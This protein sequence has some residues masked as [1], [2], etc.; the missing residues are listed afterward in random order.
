MKLYLFTFLSLFLTVYLYSCKTD[1]TLT[2][3]PSVLHFQAE[4]GAQSFTLTTDADAWK[5]ANPAPGWITLSDS[6]GNTPEA[7]ITI[8]V[9]SKTL[10]ARTDTLSIT[11]GNAGPSGIVITQEASEFL[12]S[13]NCNSNKLEFARTAGSLKFDLSTTA[14][15]WNISTQASWISISTPTGTTPVA[16]I[17]VSVTLNTTGKDRSDTLVL[18]APYAPSSLIVVTQSGALYPS[19]NTSPAQPNNT[20]MG[21]SAVQLAKNM[22]TGWN[23]G[24][25]LE[26]PGGETLWGNPK[27]SQR[28]IDSIYK[29]GFNAIRLPCAWNSYIENAITCRI[30]ESWLAR[31]KEVV[32]YCYKNNMYVLINIHWDGGWLENNCTTTKQ[33]ENNAKQKAIWEQIATYFRDYDEHLLFA[34]TNEPN[35]ENATQMGVLLTYLQTFIDAVR[36]TGGRNAYRTLVFQGPSTDIEKTSKLMTKLPID[37]VPNRLMAEIHYYT[38]WNFCGMEKDESWGK[39]FYYWGANYH[40]AADPTRNATW[41][42]ES[43]VRT[44][45]GLM[46]TQ[47]VSKGIPVILGEYAVTRRAT[48]TGEALTKHLASRA[49]YYEYVTQQAKNYGLVPFVWDNGGTGNNACGIFNRNGFSVSDKLVLEKLMTGAKNGVYPY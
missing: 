37:N 43:T 42:E 8:S 10:V 19:Y 29:A 28:L 49:Y 12:Y 46:K 35:V 15:S 7:T 16:S 14:P 30:K 45:F 31:V 23:L 38:P 39:M 11:A 18:T 33:A 2:V 22:F 32:D 26:V 25:S 6:A 21:S 36:S 44:N 1:N 17:M 34:G 3:S 13:L 48:L 9:N 41:G 40:H 20:G 47:F 4:G 24:N 27:V 5:I